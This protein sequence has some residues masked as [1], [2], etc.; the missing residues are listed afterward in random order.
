MQIVI[1]KGVQAPHSD[2][3]MNNTQRQTQ[4]FQQLSV[5][6]RNMKEVVSSIDGVGSRF[7]LCASSVSVKHDIAVL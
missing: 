1:S 7:G 6:I 2:E 3:V 5:E 4:L